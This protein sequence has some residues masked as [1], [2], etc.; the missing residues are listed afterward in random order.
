MKVIFSLLA[1]VEYYV[2]DLKLVSESDLSQTGED[3]WSV[4]SNHTGY[5]KFKLPSMK[6]EY[7]ISIIKSRV[8]GTEKSRQPCF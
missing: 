8:L 7:G 6:G 4:I 5:Y 1:W 3:N 2:P